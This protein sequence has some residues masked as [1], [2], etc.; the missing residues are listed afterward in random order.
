MARQIE[1]LFPDINNHF[2]V[3]GGITPT[4]FSERPIQPVYD[5]AKS[6]GWALFESFSADL[7]GNDPVIAGF[8]SNKSIE[9]F[10]R[11]DKDVDS[12]FDTGLGRL[13]TLPANFRYKLDVFSIH[14]P[15]ANT[16]ALSVRWFPEVD[17]GTSVD[18][19][20]GSFAGSAVFNLWNNATLG[21]L[22]TRTSEGYGGSLRFELNRTVGILDLTNLHIRLQG[23]PYGQSGTAM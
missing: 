12:K 17:T 15:A 11:F 19:A 8:V 16:W 18:M 6:D 1:R 9:W 10:R 14:V 4:E 3:P 22:V 7:V 21:N 5:M 20:V 2:S 23:V 13:Q